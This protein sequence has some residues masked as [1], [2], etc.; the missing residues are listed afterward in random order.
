M[1]AELAA[2]HEVPA[3]VRKRVVCYWPNSDFYNESKPVFEGK[4]E[5]VGGA[6]EE[7]ELKAREFQ[8][9]KEAAMVESVEAKRHGFVVD[10]VEVP[11]IP[12][13]PAGI[14]PFL[15]A[16]SIRDTGCRLAGSQG[17]TTPLW[18]R[19]TS[20]PRWIC[21]GS[22]GSSSKAC[23]IRKLSHLRTSWRS[24]MASPAVFR[25]R[26]PR[27]SRAAR[28]ATTGHARLT[29][30]MECLYT[31]ATGWFKLGVKARRTYISVTSRKKGGENR[32]N[33]GRLK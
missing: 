29:D 20:W 14:L 33:R 9:A 13:P 4:M 16:S 25:P 28:W 7:R 32:I 11:P 26:Q 6:R 24:E 3:S 15:D 21:A 22:T 19:R 31:L 10:T 27:E 18:V 12:H 30:R 8:A 17:T 1:W 5:A 2:R 23:S